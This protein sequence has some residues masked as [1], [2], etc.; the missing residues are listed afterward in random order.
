[1]SSGPKRRLKLVRLA[2]V[3]RVQVMRLPIPADQLGQVLPGVAGQ[4]LQVS[5]QHPAMALAEFE[6]S[7]SMQHRGDEP[8]P[9]RLV[10]RGGKNNVC[11]TGQKLP[12]L[13]DRVEPCFVHIDHHPS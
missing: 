5:E 13:L 11:G 9:R 1:M 12:D 4:P 3:H 6:V 7:M 8:V 10:L 2:R